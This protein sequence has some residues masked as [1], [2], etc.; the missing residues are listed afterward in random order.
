MNNLLNNTV[1][2][3]TKISDRLIFQRLTPVCIS[4]GSMITLRTG[5]VVLEFPGMSE[6]L[7]TISPFLGI[8]YLLSQFRLN[9]KLSDQVFNSELKSRSSELPGRISEEL[10]IVEVNFWFLIFASTERLLKELFL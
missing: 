5:L 6:P 3:S 9:I 7:A 1:V 2:E 10:L 4:V 8:F